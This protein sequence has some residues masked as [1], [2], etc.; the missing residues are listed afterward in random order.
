[1]LP[2]SI[3]RHWDALVPVD[4]ASAG[5]LAAVPV[6]PIAVIDLMSAFVDAGDL[7]LPPA[8]YPYG[9]GH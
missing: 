8:T 4:I 9:E 2:C 5:L 6:G 3:P 1:V 7:E